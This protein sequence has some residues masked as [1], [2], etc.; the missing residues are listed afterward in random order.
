M[1]GMLLLCYKNFKLFSRVPGSAGKS[2]GMNNGDFIISAST[3][4]KVGI[5]WWNEEEARINKVDYE[6]L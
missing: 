3:L 6:E 5:N 4:P 2:V 1:L